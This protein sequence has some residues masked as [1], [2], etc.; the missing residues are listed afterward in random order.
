MRKLLAL[1]LTLVLLATALVGCK[2]EKTEDAII[3]KGEG[4]AYTFTPDGLLY[5]M[6]QGEEEL[7][8]APL[9]FNVWRAP[10][11]VEVDSWSQGN[12]TY[13]N[14]K[15]WNGSQIANEYY[16]NNIDEITR[17]PISCEAFEADGQVYINV[18]SFAQF[19]PAVNTSLDAY[20]F[21]VRYIG[22]S[23]IYEYRING[24]GSI[25]I[26]H[27]LEPE[28]SM[29]ELLPRIGLTLT[30]NEK[31]QQVKW[32]GRGPEENYPDRKTGYPVG[33]YENNV[34][35]MFEPYLIPQDCGLRCDN[36]WLEMRSDSGHGLRFSMD[37]LFKEF[38]NGRFFYLTT[39]TKRKYT[40][41]EF[42][43]GD[44]IVFGPESRGL[45]AQYVTAQTALTI[46]MK[47]GQR[48]LNLS[49]SVAIVAYE[50]IRQLGL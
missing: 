21:G 20:I 15:A 14:R 23:E 48:S 47:E 19:G 6:K 7:L 30:L 45:P 46:P 5:S 17:M 29:P 49:N 37:E 12:I 18:R 36:R 2:E 35:G 42:Q 38:P 50:M 4:F 16:S 13:N 22:Y 40:D 11:A 43:E 9:Q 3:V 41:I 1:L 31:M 39:K 34:D 28:G 33:I 10:L 27:T 24:D 8:K 25:A 26:H 44:F 32:Y